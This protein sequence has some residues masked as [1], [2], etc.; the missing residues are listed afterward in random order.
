MIAQSVMFGFQIGEISCPTKY[1]AEASSINF[2][3]SVQYGL[4]VLG[5]TARFVAHRAGIINSPAFGAT[6][7]RI[8]QQYYTRVP[9]GS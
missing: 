1:F 2:K 6:G 7:R 3:R 4:G 9:Q 5:T 8:S